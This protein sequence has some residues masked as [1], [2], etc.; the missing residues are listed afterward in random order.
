MTQIFNHQNELKLSET[1]EIAGNKISQTLTN[2][3]K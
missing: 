2:I 3:M 1:F